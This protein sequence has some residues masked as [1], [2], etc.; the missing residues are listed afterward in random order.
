MLT[1]FELKRYDC[2]LTVLSMILKMKAAYSSETLCPLNDY[3]V[4]HSTEYNGKTRGHENI[5]V[6]TYTR[7][8]Y[9]RTRFGTPCALSFSVT[10]E[11]LVITHF[12]TQY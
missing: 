11:A 10:T 12:M 4:L 1:E 3:K 9:S 5:S 7:S 8:T 2:V 6:H